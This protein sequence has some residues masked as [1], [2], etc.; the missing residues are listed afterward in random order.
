MR[1]GYTFKVKNIFA[2]FPRPDGKGA[3][4]NAIR[5]WARK[6]IIDAYQVAPHGEW[7]LSAQGV[8]DAW[9]L[10]AQHKGLDSDAMPAE[11]ATLLAD[12]RSPSSLN[13]E[14]VVRIEITIHTAG[15]VEVASTAL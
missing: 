7:H 5:A 15:N 11:L 4:G 1:T 8:R 9:R 14:P 3:P 10:W 2:Y 13:G 12:E 6:G